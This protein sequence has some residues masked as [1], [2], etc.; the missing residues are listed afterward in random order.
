M[1][2]VNSV[3]DPAGLVTPVTL[4]GKLYQR[5]IIP[6][7]K[8]APGAHA[9][10]WDDPLPEEKREK[11]EEWVKLLPEMERIEVTRALTHPTMRPVRRELHIF[12]DASE[13]A[14]GHVAYLKTVSDQG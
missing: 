3:F 9:I 6:Q 5:E 4:K 14:I 2:S 10:G 11:W 1:G 8:K 7:K 13:A 12:C